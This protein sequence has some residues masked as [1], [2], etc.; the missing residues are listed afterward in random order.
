MT[1]F[2]EIENSI[3]KFTWRPARWFMP[4]ILATQDAESRRIIV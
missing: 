3:L 4:V 2:T 1:F